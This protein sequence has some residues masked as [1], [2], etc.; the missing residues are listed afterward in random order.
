MRVGPGIDQQP[1]TVLKENSQVAATGKTSG[2]WTE[3][4]YDGASRWISSQYLSDTCLL[5]TSRCV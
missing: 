3:V 4:S 1:V 2:D 5:Y